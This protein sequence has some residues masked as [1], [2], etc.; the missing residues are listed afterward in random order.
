MALGS[1]ASAPGPNQTA[2]LT[3]NNAFDN[4]GFVVNVG[5]GTAS[6][7]NNKTDPV[8]PSVRQAAQAVGAGIGGLLGNP[9]FVV[10][11]GVGL[12]LYLKHK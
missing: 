10:L 3:A 4:S 6:S 1:I 11:V 8:M 12:Y 5:P 2:A 7:T 9:V